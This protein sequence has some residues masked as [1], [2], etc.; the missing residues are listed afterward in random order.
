MNQLWKKHDESMNSP[1]SYPTIVEVRIF[2]RSP[3]PQ[4]DKLIGRKPQV[5]IGSAGSFMWEMVHEYRVIPNAVQPFRKTGHL[6]LAK[7]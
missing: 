7:G 6:T 3:S 5:I 1:V 2:T 4:L